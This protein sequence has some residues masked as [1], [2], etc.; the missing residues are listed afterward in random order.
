[1]VYLVE[2]FLPERQCVLGDEVSRTVA[3]GIDAPMVEEFYLVDPGWL[4]RV[5]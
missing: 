1:M 3:T 4:D 5:N 2:V